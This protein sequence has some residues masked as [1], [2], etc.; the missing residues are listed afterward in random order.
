MIERLEVDRALQDVASG[1]ITARL[2]VSAAGFWPLAFEIVAPNKQSQSPFP[3]RQL[4]RMVDDGITVRRAAII[5]ITATSG[6]NGMASGPLLHWA[7]LLTA[8][9]TNWNGVRVTSS[10]ARP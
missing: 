5:A 6:F 1:T 2:M 8:F 3:E 10:N 4:S 7:V 9:K